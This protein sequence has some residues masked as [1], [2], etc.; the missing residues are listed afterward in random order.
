MPPIKPKTK[1]NIANINEKINTKGVK[2]K[3]INKNN[4]F[5]PNSRNKNP[6][7]ISMTCPVKMYLRDCE[8]I[9]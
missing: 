2:T 6:M 4:S 7:K 5:K 8:S 1:A 3:T 9:M